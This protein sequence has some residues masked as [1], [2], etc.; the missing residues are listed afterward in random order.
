MK[1]SRERFEQL[2]SAY[3]DGEISPEDAQRLLDCVHADARV[4]NFFL[5]SCAMHA[6]LC[7][8]YGK[9]ANFQNLA[10]FDVNAALSAKRPSKYRTFAEWLVV[11]FSFAAC[12]SLMTAAWIMRNADQPDADEQ[13]AVNAENYKTLL[14][15]SPEVG[16]GDITIIKIY[17]KHS[18]LLMP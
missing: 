11:G 2:I 14:C 3:L 17:P 9:R 10:S 8:L 1:I 7:R 4:R 16:N 18:V 6:S 5:K 12:A 15:D 13:T